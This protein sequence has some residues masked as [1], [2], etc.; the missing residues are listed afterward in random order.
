MLTKCFYPHVHWG[1]VRVSR[2]SKDATLRSTSSQNGIHHALI[3]LERDDRWDRTEPLLP[4]PVI[5]RRPINY[6][7]VGQYVYHLEPTTMTRWCRKKLPML[8][9]PMTEDA[10]S[11]TIPSAIH[12]I[13]T[14]PI[15]IASCEHA[16]V[17]DSLVLRKCC[18]KIHRLHANQLQVFVYYRRPKLIG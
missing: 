16:K 2:G 6:C 18:V 4:R 9:G 5:A 10:V 11:Q 7:D 14:F 1:R 12:I 17:K 8:T 15:R 13:P 3:Q